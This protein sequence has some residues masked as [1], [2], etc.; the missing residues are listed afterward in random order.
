MYSLILDLV[1]HQNIKKKNKSVPTIGFSDGICDACRYYRYIKSK[2]NW[3][4][5]EKDLVKLCNK[6]RDKNAQ[7]DVLVPG[8]GGKDSIFVSEILKKKI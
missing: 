8:S 1:H 4:Q 6:Y 2:I 3:K 7:Y 5:R